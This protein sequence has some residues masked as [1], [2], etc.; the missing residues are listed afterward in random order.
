MK[1]VSDAEATHLNA[2]AYAHESILNMLLA[3]PRT[4]FH[5]PWP[6]LPTPG[7]AEDKL[8]A[9]IDESRRYAGLFVF[10]GCDDGADGGV[11]AMC[12]GQV[13]VA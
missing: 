9:L 2:K 11:Y 1:L 6:E 4:W 10:Y 12:A 7:T 3:H 5:I 13:A 8:H